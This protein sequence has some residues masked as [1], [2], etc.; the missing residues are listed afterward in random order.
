M[1][2]IEGMA[3]ELGGV[4]EGLWSVL[5]QIG[6]EQYRVNVLILAMEREIDVTIQTLETLVEGIEDDVEVSVLLNGAMNG[7]FRAICESLPFVNYYES[8]RNLGVAGGRNFLMAQGPCRKSDIVM[9]LDND[10]IPTSD[11]V[12]SLCTFLIEN[13][14]AGVVGAT[15]L[16]V[17][18]FW[19][20][21]R[22][23]FPTRRG[24][25]G[26]EIFVV[27]NS[28]IRRLLRESARSEDFYHIGINE[29]WYNTYFHPHDLYLKICNSLGLLSEE[30]FFPGLKND[31]EYVGIYRRGDTVK[32]EVSNVIGCCQTFRRKLVDDIGPLNDMFSPYGFED[33]DLSIRSI[34]RGLKNYTHT[35]TF[36]IHGTDERHAERKEAAAKNRYACNQSRCLTILGYLH[37]PEKWEDLAKRRMFYR[38][39]H[40]HNIIG[41]SP[42]ELLYYDLKGY[43]QAVQ[44]IENLAANEPAE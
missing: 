22:S 27:S 12:R 40:A 31:P 25:F 38:Y 5:M 39:I 7:E 10:V 18:P 33:V 13:P 23:R 20:R 8:P 9:F 15:V 35:N 19:R 32:F 6:N 21:H 3:S 11:Y 30:R 24:S 26:N 44:Q 2:V 41:V 42:S 14:D 28:D 4:R 36:L 16:N 34:K 43:H 17:R 37:F 29:D 1:V